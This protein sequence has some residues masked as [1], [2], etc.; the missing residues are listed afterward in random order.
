MCKEERETQLG[1]VRVGQSDRCFF[2]GEMSEVGG[3]SVAQKEFQLV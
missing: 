1:A 3:Y 2:V